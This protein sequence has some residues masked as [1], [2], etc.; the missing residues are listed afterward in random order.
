MS[1]T[2]LETTRKPTDPPGSRL[3]AFPAPRAP[4]F[5]VLEL[6]VVVAII[7]VLASIA[8]PS[9]T[10]VVKQVRKVCCQAQMAGLAKGAYT[11][12][13]DFDGWL[14]PGPV[15]RGFWAG[16]P[17]RGLPYELYNARR[18]EDPALNSRNGWYG[19]GLIWKSAYVDRGELFYCPSAGRNGGLKRKQAWPRSFDASRDPS[20]GKSRVCSTIAYRGGLSSQAGTS[21]GPINVSRSSAGD[22]MLADNPCA[23]RMWHDGGYNIA[24]VDAHVQ[25]YDFGSPIVSDGYLPA[26]W[27]AVL[28][29]ENSRVASGARSSGLGR[30]ACPLS[31]FGGS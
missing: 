22:P 29:N 23:G 31:C 27:E 28:S 26:L 24:F 9:M 10:S 15:E 12:T 11:Y 18:V 6:L 17:D 16:D 4:A 5:T 2:W 8:I 25:F 7:S 30:A 1:P 3:V 14:P 13:C 19:L 20:D 21:L